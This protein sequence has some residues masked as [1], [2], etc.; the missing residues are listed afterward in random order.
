MKILL[1]GKESSISILLASRLKKEGF[2]VLTTSRRREQ[3]DSIKLDLLDIDSFLNNPPE[4]DIVIIL[5]A[6][7]K[8]KECRDNFVEA[9]IINNEAPVKLASY[10]SQFGTKIIFLSSSAVFDGS[11]P[12]IYSLEPQNARSEYGKMKAF[13]EQDLL[14]INGN[15]SVLRFSKVITEERNIF[16]TWKDQLLKGFAITCFKDQYISPIDSKVACDI[17]VLLIKKSNNGIYQFSA[18]SDMSYYEIA[19]ELSKLINVNKKNI[20]P[21]LAIDNQIYKE[22]IFR[23]TSLDT[24]RILNEFNILAPTPIDFLDNLKNI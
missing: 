5:A 17:L 18:N 3:V 6:I 12:N 21:V 8:F 4:V 15:I 11:R 2:E 13:A 10:Y 24:S 7:S 22:E 20:K 9:N 16:S 1:I 23:Y 19:T 14:R